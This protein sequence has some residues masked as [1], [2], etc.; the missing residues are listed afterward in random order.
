MG[1]GKKVPAY[2]RISNALRDT[3]G[4]ISGATSVKY[5]IIIAG[6]ALVIVASLTA[7]GGDLTGYIEGIWDSLAID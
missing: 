5:V 1:K 3:G 6:I 2:I 7:F 4:D